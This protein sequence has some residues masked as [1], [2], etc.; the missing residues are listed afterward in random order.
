MSVWPSHRESDPNYGAVIAQLNDRWRVIV[1]RD[2]IQW[3]LQKS[4]KSRVGARWQGRSYCRTREALM[5][6]CAQH[7]GQI[8]PSA[9]MI[10][11]ALPDRINQSEER[12]GKRCNDSEPRFTKPQRMRT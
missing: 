12:P 6:V 7:G 3:I 4:K 5:R 8:D 10:L 1:C 9:L 2:G 11:E